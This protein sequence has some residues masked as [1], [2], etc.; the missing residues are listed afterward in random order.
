MM[1]IWVVMG[2]LLVACA[3]DDAVQG[4][5]DQR[6]AAVSDQFSGTVGSD[7]GQRQ[8]DMFS[9]EDI[10]V[11]SSP[12]QDVN[13]PIWPEGAALS[14]ERRGSEIEVSWPEASDD[15]S[16]SGYSVYV[17][18]ELK[19]RT[20]ATQRMAVLSSLT[21]SL[22]YEIAVVASDDAMNRSTP[23]ST[24]YEHLD[25]EAPTWLSSS[26]IIITL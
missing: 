6:D 1:R 4:P 25:Q 12:T 3:D 7:V 19:A 15:Q 11:P 9:T 24:R 13:R 17:D 22:T 8:L 21:S 23:L 16:V 18:G 10:Y 26:E 2:V 20:R 14:I 5:R